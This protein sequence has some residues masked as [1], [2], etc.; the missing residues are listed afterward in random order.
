MKC[1]EEDP[2]MLPEGQSVRGVIDWD[3][4]EPGDP[5]W[6]VG[7]FAWYAVPL[8]GEDHWREPGFPPGRISGPD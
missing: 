6:D 3:F 7:Q 4:A 2:K 8:R 1:S 5:L